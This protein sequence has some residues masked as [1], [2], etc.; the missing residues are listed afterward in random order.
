MDYL[1]VEVSVNAFL[2]KHMFALKS[3]LGRNCFSLKIIFK[4]IIM[5]ITEYLGVTTRFNYKILTAFSFPLTALYSDFYLS[6]ILCSH[7]TFPSCKTVKNLFPKFV[8]LY[9][10]MLGVLCINVTWIFKMTSTSRICHVGSINHCDPS[11]SRNILLIFV[12]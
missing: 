8:P 3:L 11:I 2:R 6:Y 9:R 12:L 5:Y 1:R 10:E 4:T 7:L